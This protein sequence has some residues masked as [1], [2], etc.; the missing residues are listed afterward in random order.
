MNQTVHYDDILIPMEDNNEVV[1]LSNF[2]PS[3]IDHS[4]NKNSKTIAIMY[5]YY[6]LNNK[7]KFLYIDIKR[8]FRKNN[9]RGTI[10]KLFNP[11]IPLKNLKMP[12]ENTHQFVTLKCVSII[13]HLGKTEDS[14]HYVCT[15]NKDKTD[16]WYLYDDME[17][18]DIYIGNFQEMLNY[19]YQDDFI[20]KNCTGIVYM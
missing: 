10:K 7:D 3:G 17:N 19:K 20:I 5:D 6:L 12:V 4:I 1:E 8:Y 15:Y 13:V 18:E 2:L 9:K 11:I 14:G 16:Q